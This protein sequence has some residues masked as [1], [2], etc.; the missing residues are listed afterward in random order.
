MTKLDLTEIKKD[1]YRYIRE[2]YEELYPCMGSRVMS[3]VALLPPSLILPPLTTS[4]GKKIPAKINC[5]LLSP[6]GTSKTSLSERFKK[7]TYDPFIFE[8]ITDAKLASVLSYKTRVSVIVSDIARVFSNPILNKQMENITGEEG[9]ISRFTMKTK[10]EE[11]KLDAVAFLSGTPENLNRTITDGLLFRVSPLLVFH[12]EREH[13]SILEKV[14][15]DIGKGKIEN[16]I[17]REQVIIEYYN[18][19]LDI[20]EGEH[21]EIE[22]ITGYIIDDEFRNKIATAINPKLDQIFKNTNYEFVRELQQ[23]WKYAIAHAFLNVFQ[24]TIEKGKLVIT[25]EDI[26]KAIALS[27]REIETKEKILESLRDISTKKF[28]TVE[29]LKRWANA[30]K[31]E[32]NKPVSVDDYKIRET[33]LTQNRI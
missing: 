18:E 1:P 13:R 8:S 29:D 31:K 30:K 19:L 26:A 27:S 33:L 15:G 12:T 22:Q 3:I 11:I 21:K 25:E 4:N 14:N 23:V 5:L 6:A 7:F 17:D 24:R 16:E 32:S 2:F 20:Q 28:R 9:K 10:E